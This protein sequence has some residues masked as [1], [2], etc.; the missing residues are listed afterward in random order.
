MNTTTLE[1][2]IWYE[3]V[4]VIDKDDFTQIDLLKTS[5]IHGWRG[6]VFTPNTIQVFWCGTKA[7]LYS[8][9]SVKSNLNIT[10]NDTYDN[11]NRMWRNQPKC[12]AYLI[13]EIID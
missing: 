10:F 2:P 1:Q 7:I 4:I 11:I 6:L 5:H 3:N 13:T 8:D 12:P 9:N